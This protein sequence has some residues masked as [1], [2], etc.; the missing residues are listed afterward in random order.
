MGH[1]GGTHPRKEHRPEPEPISH[2]TVYILNTGEAD[3]TA[4][5]TV[6]HRSRTGRSVRGDGSGGTNWSGSVSAEPD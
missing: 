4:E 6:F 2:E 5:I 1:S 3:A